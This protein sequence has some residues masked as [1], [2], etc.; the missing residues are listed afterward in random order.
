MSAPRPSEDLAMTESELI[1]WI[2]NQKQDESPFVLKGVGDDCAVLDSTRQSRL[3]V[4]T[5]VLV[6]GVHFRRRWMHP[7]FLGRKAL[8]VNLSDLA[9]MGALPA[10]CLLTLTLP[11]GLTGDFF[12]SFM[13]GFL[14][15][16]R[17]WKAPLVG[18][19]LSRGSSVHVGVTIWGHLETGEAVYRSTAAAGDAVVLVGDVG[20]SAAGLNLLKR[21][22]PAG[23]AAIRT[24]A[25]LAGWAGDAFRWRCLKSHFLP[26]PQIQAGD[27]LR[28]NGFAGAMI[29]VSDGLRID[30]Q[31]LCGDSGLSF[32]PGS[33]I[34]L[35][36]GLT[37]H[38]SREAALG[39][40]EDYALLAA[41]PADRLERFRTGYPEHLTAWRQIGSLREPGADG[42]AEGDPFDGF[43][44]FA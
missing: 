23:L 33:R 28:R 11:P 26:T 31:R 24:E 39:G 27:W 19:D 37:S 3:V 16:V 8:L 2:R 25:E 7:Y 44:H 40:G 22:D 29:D 6:E 15:E 36:P 20:L 42:G 4:S 9:A 10:A 34:P 35:E 32:E 21:E 5:D 43:D 18:G 13:D 14:E 38:I 17:R 41:I 30:L 12:R 1:R